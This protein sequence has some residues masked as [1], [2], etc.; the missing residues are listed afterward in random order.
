MTYES[1]KAGNWVAESFAVV[2]NDI[3]LLGSSV[4]YTRFGDALSDGDTVF[5][6]AFDDN[7]NREAGYATYSSGK[8][9]DRV[10]TATLK[11]GVYAE[12]ENLPAVD[13]NGS[14]KTVAGTFNQV[15]FE[16][17]WG[18][19]FDRENP[20]EVIA[21]QVPQNPANG[22]GDNVQEALDN[23]SDH[24]NQNTQDLIDHENN[25]GNPHDVKADQVDL[26]PAFVPAGD[27]VQTALEKIYEQFHLKAGNDEQLYLNFADGDETFIQMRRR[28]RED[29]GVKPAYDGFWNK[30]EGWSGDI[31]GLV[32]ELH[33]FAKEGRVY[34]FLEDGTMV[35]IASQ[36][37]FED[38]PEDGRTWARKDG[39]WV[40]V[41]A[42]IIADE[43]P[44][45]I[46]GTLW[47]DTGTTAELYVYDGDNWISMTGAGSGGG[48]ADNIVLDDAD[49]TMRNVALAR[50]INTE[51]DGFWR[52]IFTSDLVTENNQPMFAGRA[53]DGIRNQKDANWYLLNLIE[54]LPDC[55]I[56]DRTPE[57]PKEGD[58][59]FDNSEDVMQLFIFHEDSDAYVPVAPP[60]TLEGR[61][62][63]GETTQQAIIKQIQQSLADQSE[64]E[65]RIAT[66][67]AT[68]Q[69]IIAQIQKSLEDQAD[70][71]EKI[72][73]GEAG[74]D[75]LAERVSDGETE[76]ETL[77]NKISALEGAVGEHSLVL[78]M[79]NSNPRPGEFNLKDGAMQVT[80]TLASA[81]YITL[82]DTDRN[83]NAI[84]LDRITEGDVLRFSSIDGQAAELKITDGT[85]GVY[86][87]TKVSGELDRLSE[88]PH[89]FILLSSFDPAG[90]AT[91]DY[92]DE[93]DH[94]KI[95]RSGTWTLTENQAWK[96]R[97]KD[98]SDSDKTF[99]TIYDG[100]MN[101]YHV[102]TPTS[103]M[104]GAN[105]LYVDQEIA[106]AVANLPQFKPQPAYLMWEYYNRGDSAPPQD[107][108]FFKN[109]DWWHFSYKTKNGVDLGGGPPSEKEWYA[110]QG[111][112]CKYEMTL[113]EVNDGV[114]KM[115]KHIECYKASWSMDRQGT[116]YFA[117]KH[118]WQ[119][120]DNSCRGGHK[121]YITVGGFF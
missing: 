48:V 110:P 86:A 99:L 34:T 78:T 18:H 91:I 68:Q 28:Y 45:P 97:Q 20:H 66:G 59:W 113:W 121:Y 50:E 1:A 65:G 29:E 93:R 116:K 7:N 105:K 35:L 61:V 16:E 103:A 84:N 80:N 30:P 54:G 55:V 17:L 38:A 52:Q 56:S 2:G 5:Y 109:N 23:L 74:Q 100:T 24:V 19:I 87:F 119:S 47:Y 107:G 22:R 31:S 26:S 98:L 94:T 82:S 14:N 60:T 44:A 96:L 85:A 81:D 111:G 83:G 8:L 117:F 118:T 13:F 115:F 69:D 42:T 43:P 6:S 21:E 51:G 70:L 112:D 64:L 67:E 72:A 63:T 15:A 106:K 33:F 27:N 4:G 12:G 76:Q 25:V 39:A 46:T 9:T 114:W 88:H 3:S 108:Q 77:K 41:T 58:L 36:Y 90:L 71:A 89:D 95:G 75:E 32:G 73:A 79:D 101:L 104:H 40:E 120:H 10:I 92:V 62:T 102:D 53:D 49:A 37:F 11:A 57:D